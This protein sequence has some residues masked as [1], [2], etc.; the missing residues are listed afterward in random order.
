MDAP[1]TASP[2]FFLSYAREDDESGAVERLYQDLRGRLRMT[3]G[4]K[5]GL[6]FRD[7]SQIKP[8]ADWSAELKGA[9]ETAQSFVAVLSPTYFSRQY[10]GKEWEAFSCRLAPYL[11]RPEAA[12]LLQPVLLVGKAHLV[13][14]P[15]AVHEKQYDFDRYP[16]EYAQRGFTYLQDLVNAGGDLYK[17]FLTELTE[18]IATAV[19]TVPIAPMSLPP[20]ADIPSAFHDQATGVKVVPAGSA[21]GSHLFAQ[22]VYVAA[23]NQELTGLREERLA[24]GDLGGLDWQPFRP[25]VDDEIGIIAAAVTAREKFR[26]ER[27]EI[28]DDLADRLSAATEENKVVVVVVDPWTVRLES[29][30]RLMRDLDRHSLPTCVVIIP[31]NDT[32]EETARNREVLGGIVEATFV[33]RNLAPDVETFIV[34]VASKDEL[35]AKLSSALASAKSRVLRRYQIGAGANGPGRFPSPPTVSNH[36]GPP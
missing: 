16:E 11:N 15:P 24:Y 36:P 28:G 25:P 29:Y 22:F 19:R 4:P 14:M 33:N 2:S 30:R 23:R 31:F 5:Y 10:C 3:L 34:G 35:E 21:P 13:P 12:S 6:G 9:L 17:R 8:G 1:E 7:R 26:Y 18:L 32:D 27:V 20:I